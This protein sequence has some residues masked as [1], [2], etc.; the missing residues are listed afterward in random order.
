MLPIRTRGQERVPEEREKEKFL[1]S[2]PCRQP[3]VL[4]ARCDLSSQHKL[5]TLT[6]QTQP[7]VRNKN[8]GNKELNYLCRHSSGDETTECPQD[9]CAVHS[10]SIYGHLQNQH[11]REILH[12]LCWA[13]GSG[14]TSVEDTQKLTW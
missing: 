13:F 14:P 1:A 12:P 4:A 11:Y 3:W 2:I 8:N 5:V 6:N 9:N 7:Q 10:L